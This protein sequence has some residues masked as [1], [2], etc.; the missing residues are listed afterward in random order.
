MFGL[1]FSHRSFGVAVCAL[2]KVA[3]TCFFLA[4]EWAHGAYRH[5]PGGNSR[6][7]RLVF[8]QVPADAQLFIVAPYG[9]LTAGSDEYSRII[10]YSR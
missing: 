5:D 8:V 2:P 4:F 10:R 6:D 9:A 1:M 7:F 3:I